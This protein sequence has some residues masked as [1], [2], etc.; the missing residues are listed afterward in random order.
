MN[1]MG[2]FD[3]VY[4]DCPHCGQHTELQSKAGE[5]MLNS[6]T[7]K[8]APRNVLEDLAYGGGWRKCKHCEEEIEIEIPGKP[9]FTVKKRNN[10]WG[11][12]E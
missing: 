4:V 12:I 10:E 11:D 9:E 2:M 8:T 7:L 6:W 3:R 5:C 1:F